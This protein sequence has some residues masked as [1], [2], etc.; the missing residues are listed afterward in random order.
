M[1]SFQ[2]AGLGSDGIKSWELLPVL[3]S[4]NFPGDFFPLGAISRR[5]SALGWGERQPSLGKGGFSPHPTNS[6]C[7]APSP[8]FLSKPWEC[9]KTTPAAPQSSGMSWLEHRGR[10]WEDGWD[11]YAFQSAGNTSLALPSPFGIFVTAG[12]TERGPWEPREGT[13]SAR[14]PFLWGYRIPGIPEIPGIPP[15]QP[16]LG[17][18]FQSPANSPDLPRP[19]S[20]S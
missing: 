12:G 14:A 8:N 11:F 15:H 1:G 19:K 3:F 10:F 5:C 17:D 13:P 16:S 7:S 2:E 18:G 4:P 9:R 6:R 20:P